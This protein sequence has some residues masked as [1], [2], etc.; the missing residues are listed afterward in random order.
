MYEIPI[1][2]LRMWTPR[3][4]RRSTMLAMLMWALAACA[5]MQGPGGGPAPV[6]VGETAATTVT[7]TV[8]LRGD[9]VA[10]RQITVRSPL[11]GTVAQIVV[12]DG[13]IVRRGQLLVQLDDREWQANVKD[14]R[15]SFRLAKLELAR[16][17]KL[18]AQEAISQS[19]LDDA[20]AQR[21]AAEAALQLAE[22]RVDDAAIEAPF[23][24]RIGI[25]DISEGQV[26][27]QSNS[28]TTLVELDPILVEF[29]VPERDAGALRTGMPVQ[30]RSELDRHK[31]VTATITTINPVA[32]MQT[33]TI[34]VRASLHNPQNRW[35][36][37][38]SATVVLPRGAPREAVEVPEQALIPSLD[39]L[40][41][42]TVERDKARAHDVRV[43]QRRPGFAAVEATFPAG[44]T[45]IT[46]GHHRLQDGKAIKILPKEQETAVPAAAPTTDA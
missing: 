8:T 20:V 42:Y 36:P 12:G 32:N 23:P 15:A 31:T 5:D 29:P 41:I 14:A 1:E 7:P 40:Q 33:R 43:L 10:R 11:A 46:T 30:V 13:A 25:F 22:V 18:R 19:A 4:L 21:D 3:T 34:R 16:T 45:V 44:A 26:I 37:G 27:D 17:R 39:R 35:L 38:M 24:G 6:N 9:F 28:L 2:N